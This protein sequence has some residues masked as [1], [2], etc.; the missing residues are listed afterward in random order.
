MMEVIILVVRFLLVVI[1]QFLQQMI[2]NISL[3]V[4]MIL[5]LIRM[6]GNTVHFFLLRKII[7]ITHINY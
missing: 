6:I 2:K 5:N 3:K 7:V 1:K 4:F